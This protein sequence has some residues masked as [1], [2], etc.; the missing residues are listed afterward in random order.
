[1]MKHRILNWLTVLTLLPLSAS[2]SVTPGE[3]LLGPLLSEF[4][5]P[6]L[7]CE[8]IGRHGADADRTLSLYRETLSRLELRIANRLLV[9]S[10]S[11]AL[12]TA[13]LERNPAGVSGFTAT[14]DA[15]LLDRR[16]SPVPG[17]TL[18]VGFVDHTGTS[19]PLFCGPVI[20][21]RSDSR[22]SMVALSALQ[23]VA[24]AGL[25]HTRT[26]TDMKRA[27]IVGVV[28]GEHGLA[29]DIDSSA[30]HPTLRSVV[31]RSQS[32]WSF[33]RS[34]AAAD[35]MELLLTPAAVL[36]YEQ[37]AFSP[38]PS[39]V[40]SRLFSEMNWIEIIGNLASELGLQL[41]AEET[42]DFP[43]VSARQ[44]ETNLAFAHR[45]ASAQGRSVYLA[46]GILRLRN[47]G[48]WRLPADGAVP[49]AGP[50]AASRISASPER[51]FKA[52]F[53]AARQPAAYRRTTRSESGIDEVSL[54]LRTKVDP[55][56]ASA[57]LLTLPMNRAI[58]AS[59]FRSALQRVQHLAGTAPRERFLVE[60]ATIHE[61]SLLIAWNLDDSTRSALASLGRV[62]AIPGGPLQTRP[63][64]R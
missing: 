41:D 20:A 61:P 16:V 44:Q 12:I 10:D 63:P 6:Q 42:A 2:A 24:G 19:Q 56:S 32:D 3:A 37:S 34:L 27:D 21:L 64:S 5:R 33:L 39:P 31:Q 7:R 53:S 25:R 49:A 29:V 57:A 13:I 26:F 30:S 40:V 51:G 55:K 23:A 54:G 45:L 8:W 4:T 52:T 35:S 47:D 58:D 22:G 48:M 62:S 18:E 9:R 14:L 28:A 15:S 36:R 50:A 46:S 1:M 60:L 17:D 43:A 59:A 38:P 11:G